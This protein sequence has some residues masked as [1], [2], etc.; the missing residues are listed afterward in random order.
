M[1]RRISAGI[2]HPLPAVPA[3]RRLARGS[4]S[5]TQEK[6]GFL[7]KHFGMLFEM[8][9]TGYSMHPSF[10]IWR[11]MQKLWVAR[12][13]RFHSLTSV[14]Y[15]HQFLKQLELNTERLLSE[16]EPEEAEETLLKYPSR[17]K[18]A[19]VLNACT[20]AN[21]SCPASC[22]SK[23][24]S[25]KVAQLATSTWRLTMSAKGSASANTPSTWWTSASTST[26]CIGAEAPNSGSEPNSVS[27]KSS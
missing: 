12:M 27:L 2:H 19:T 6:L 13:K 22:T 11:T 14:L 5:L 18:V 16:P 10:N 3:H 26:A 1:P 24:S 20:L 21:A 15:V 17:S 25:A 8:G 23:S 4:D 7:W 9:Y